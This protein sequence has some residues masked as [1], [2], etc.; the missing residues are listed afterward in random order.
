MTT[1]TTVT[2]VTTSSGNGVE[3]VG[4][5]VTFTISF[6]SAI[7]VSGGTPT[8]TLNDGGIAAYDAAAT[9]A[10]GD[11]TKLVFTYTVATSDQSVTG[12][13]FVRGDQNGAVIF[14][15][16]TGQGPD[17][18]NLFAANFPDIQVATSPT[19]VTSVVTSPANGVE[20]AGDIVTFTIAF[21]RAVTISGGTPALTL[22]DGGIATYDAAATAALGDATKAV[23]TYTVKA[24][25]QP[26]TGLSFVR[27]D[28]NGAVIVDAL[29][30][31]PD[32]T[33]IFT[34]RFP[35]IQVSQP[36]IGGPE[37][38]VAVTE[39]SQKN[40]Q[41]AALANG[42]FVVTWDDGT[43]AKAQVFAPDG[44]KISNE[45]L[46]DTPE[47]PSSHQQILALPNGGF[48]MTWL[49]GYQGL[50]SGSL[51]DGSGY[52]VM[53]QMFAADGTKT[54]SNILVNTATAGDQAAAKMTAL[55]NG[56]FVVTWQDQSHG[57]GGTGGDTSD[58]AIKAQ[59][60]DANGTRIGS[61]IL[62]NTA[63]SNSQIY[64]AI[65]ALSNGGYV[66]TWGDYS[67]GVGGATGNSDYEAVKAQ[68]FAADGTRIGAEIL[69]NTAT[70]GQQNVPLVTGLANGGFVV[71]WE[72]Y[73]G[74]PTAPYHFS[75]SMQ[76]FA[77]DGAKIG[78]EIA[79]PGYPG[80]TALS[81]GAF[82]VTTT[83]DGF[84]GGT[85]AEVSAQLFAA[86]GT[87]IGAEVVVNTVTN[88]LQS[89]A[90][91]SALSDGGFV[92][93][94]QDASQ[95]GTAIKAQIFAGDGT[96]IGGEMQVNVDTP[97]NQYDQQVTALPDGRFAVT[98][99]DYGPGNPPGSPIGTP[100]TDDVKAR[101]FDPS[102]NVT[103]IAAASNLE[104]A[105]A[106]AAR[107][108]FAPGGARLQLDHSTAFIGQIN[109][110]GDADTIDLRDVAFGSGTTLGYKANSSNSGG[111]LT[112]S[113][114]AHVSMLALLGQYTAA[115]FVL[116]S[117][118]HGGT[119]IASATAQANT[120]VSPHA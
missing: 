48:V 54:G 1:P 68:V 73:V 88:G 75:Y 40:S 23:F 46:A 105:T 14:D 66:V 57:V 41:I 87:K 42:D 81:N 18:T 60:F 11:P 21:N 96:K 5:T 103:V 113:D 31:G 55:S 51:G 65:T 83:G 95:G 64:P 72:S 90:K 4:D 52:A 116:G 92:V 30:Q 110:F 76:M 43:Q 35:N 44:S 2:S 77:A 112:V 16:S 15:T 78:S 47:N 102:P 34:A 49:A 26:A 3:H 37:I 84:A 62:V 71:T 13:S 6:D 29:G 91:V 10:L 33:N 106:T 108:A 36:D 82:V 38:A 70:A 119:A 86:D 118:G 12:L 67:A 74:S 100:A 59:V 7:T 104:I 53:A 117:D 79:L 89:D 93:T 99:T 20:H 19:A 22:N 69:V 120:L 85:N 63:T 24:A 58:S 50:P 61:E 107:L 111:T 45:I 8:L 9:A 115:S 25:D 97:Y 28:Q 27:G 32:F 17:F 56:G 109:G 114:G 101:V 94:W 39:N 98:W 80:V